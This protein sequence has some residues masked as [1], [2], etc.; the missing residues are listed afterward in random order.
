MMAI[1]LTGLCCALSVLCVAYAQDASTVSGEDAVSTQPTSP[2]EGLGESETTEQSSQGPDAEDTITSQP[3]PIEESLPEES[4]IVQTGDEF[5]EEMDGRYP[6]RITTGAAILNMEVEFV[7]HCW[8]GM[9]GLYKRDYAASKRA[10]NH[11][12]QRWRGSGVG[13]V[14]QMLAWQALMLENFDLRYSD[15][16]E[17]TFKRARQGLEQALVM[18]GN[19]VWETFLLGAVLGVDAIHSLRKGELITAINRGLEAMK[20]VNR[21]SELA[22]DFVDAQLGDGLWFYWRSVIALNTPGI[23]AFSDQRAKGITL[24]Q[25]AQTHA[26]F[27]QP[28]AYHALTYTWIE[29]GRMNRALAA[30]S[31]LARQYPNQ[32]INLMVLGRVQM[33]KRMLDEAEATYLSVLDIDPGNMR[34]HYYLQ[35]LYIRKRALSKSIEHADTYLSFDDISATH[36][37]YSLYYKGTVFHQLQD[38]PAAEKVYA[39]AW[40]VSRLERA[41]DKLEEIEAQRNDSQ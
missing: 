27:L 21:A 14:G 13:P 10:F 32:I 19:E 30:S 29:E 3:P 1:R 24:M 6:R 40:E 34:V 16:Y 7:W 4:P 36:R 2:T 23:P 18:P 20:Y 5:E 38:L 26:V 33:Y 31:L 25:Y 41:K 12:D 17:L 37:G 9:E 11:V 28:A 22:P 39:E 15:Q 35:R 8:L